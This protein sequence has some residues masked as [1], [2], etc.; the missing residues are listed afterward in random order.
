[1]GDDLLKEIKQ[2]LVMDGLLFSEV[3]RYCAC[4]YCLGHNP[5]GVLRK[6]VESNNLNIQK[7]VH[8]SSNNTP[9]HESTLIRKVKRIKKPLL[10]VTTVREEGAVLSV[11]MYVITNHCSVI[12]REHFENYS[13][14]GEGSWRRQKDSE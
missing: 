11:H 7:V 12:G 13:Y 10:A 1:M 3:E 6:W 2:A 14:K 4:G 5:L 9:M 8:F